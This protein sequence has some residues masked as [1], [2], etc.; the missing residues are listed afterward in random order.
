MLQRYICIRLRNLRSSFLA[1]YSRLRCTHHLLQ[2]FSGNV[3]FYEVTREPQ[4]MMKV[5]EGKRPARPSSE[6]C[7]SRALDDSVWALVEIC[8]HQ[9]PSARPTASKAVDLIL[10][11]RQQENMDHRTQHGWDT[12]FV[13]EIRSDLEG[14]PFQLLP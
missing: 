10:R 3:P 13:R 9:N 4:V 6:I 5:V 11:S 12:V 14:H 7:N 2:I 8:W 1:K